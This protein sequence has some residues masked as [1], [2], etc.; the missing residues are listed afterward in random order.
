MNWITGIYAKK[1]SGARD[2]LRN[3]KR[4]KHTTQRTYSYYKPNGVKIYLE[5]QIN[6]F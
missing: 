4:L 5:L 2:T 3:V 6:P 1:S